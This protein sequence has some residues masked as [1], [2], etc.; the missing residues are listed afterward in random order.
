M[1]DAINADWQDTM[2]PKRGSDQLLKD[3]VGVFLVER[4]CHKAFKSHGLDNSYCGNTNARP[5]T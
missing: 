3:L 4:H 5:G 1:L 2:L